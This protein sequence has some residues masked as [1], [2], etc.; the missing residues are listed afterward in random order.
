MSGEPTSQ[1]PV[2]E[3]EWRRLHPLSPLLRGGLVLIV[4]AGI[5]I[6]NLRD[7][8]I[9]LFL[10][11]GVVD[12]MGP[13]EG[14]IIDYL[15][16]RSLLVWALLGVA[17]VVLLIIGG[18]WLSWRFSTYRITAEAVEVKHGVLFRQHRRAPLERIQSVNLQRSLLA[19]ILGLTQ[20]DVQTAGQGGKVAL[21]FL[22]HNDAKI[23]REQILL[24]ARVSKAGAAGVSGAPANGFAA[25][26]AAPSGMVPGIAAPAAIDP[27]TGLPYPAP[28]PAPAQQGPIAV[29]FAGQPYTVAAG[30]I[31]SRLRDLADF[32][33]DPSARASGMMIKVPV[34]RLIGSILLS[35]EMI[36][37]LGVVAAIIIGSIFAS[38]FMLAAIF[39]FGIVMVGVL[40]AQFNKG[41]NFVLSRAEDGVRI[42]AGLT[43][44]STETIP[45]GRVH[46]VEAMQPLGWR[47]F[48][49][50]KVRITTAGHSAAEAGQNKMQNTVLPVGQLEDVVRV[51]ETLLHEGGPGFEDRHAALRDALIG[52]GEGYTKAGRRGAWL[53]W[54][55]VRR[56]GV[57]IHQPN[58]P[59]ASLRIR[60]GWLTRSLSVMPIVRAQSVQFTRSFGHYLLGL[61]SIKA[62][63][64]LGPVRVQ[65]RGLELSEAQQFFD[66]LAA[67]VVYVQGLDATSRAGA[68]SVPVRA[69][70][71]APVEYPQ[72]PRVD[73]PPA[74]YQPP[75]Q[76]PLP[77][78]YQPPVQQP[79][80][81]QAPWNP[82]Q[83]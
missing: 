59:S 13:N 50:W 24:A 49:W 16:G 2:L 9:E 62:H 30:A 57:Q 56:A 48:G 17:V 14:D 27:A 38:P 83:Q 33:I 21:Q 43:A 23:V 74:Q 67:N 68:Q 3:T 71:A 26:T 5:V 54:F 42:G 28:Q 29:D 81:P 46:A 52:S 20:V 15:A 37:M 19:R 51:F 36:V 32:D 10:A 72:Q 64:V 60:R 77:P 73:Q 8:F 4:V 53:L 79:Q 61:A 41:F 35:S 58:D 75:V 76:P 45:F 69:A 44:T 12:A 6:A 55:G 39:P 47:P 25:G 1:P 63:T 34:G 7:R 65:M 40:I 82:E 80:Q 18:A 11:R 78:Q 66:F 31:D 70:H 22:G